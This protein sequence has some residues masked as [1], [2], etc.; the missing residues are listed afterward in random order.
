M[1]PEVTSSMAQRVAQAAHQFQLQRTGRPPAAVTVVLSESTLVITLH[2][3]LSAAERAMAQTPEGA[4]QVQE[5]HRQLFLSSV[6]TMRDDIRRI[7]GVEVR[8]A[9]VEVETLTG[10]V[11]HAFT[12]GTMVQV[13]QL[14]D[15]I[16][17]AAWN[18]KDVQP[19]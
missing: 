18:A 10:S 14:A 3:A 1:T 6:A 8:E 19:I 7:T 11:V 12:S 2:E 13:F 4:A 15:V 17:T 5:F 9:A 16:S